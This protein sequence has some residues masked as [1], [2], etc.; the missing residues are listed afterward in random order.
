MSFILVRLGHDCI[1]D[2]SWTLLL[3]LRW[4]CEKKYQRCAQCDWTS[5]AIPWSTEW[6]RFGV[7]GS[8]GNSSQM[9]IW[10]LKDVR[11]HLQE[12]AGLIL[13]AISS[14]HYSVR[15]RWSKNYLRRCIIWYACHLRLP[16]HAG[17]RS[18]QRE[19]FFQELLHFKWSAMSDRP[20][21]FLWAH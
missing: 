17:I 3:D 11:W 4:M 15:S 20:S 12:D 13:A 21:V 6:K 1:H 16:A 19:T 10:L 18:C 14:W 2:H 8:R 5:E 7:L 9:S